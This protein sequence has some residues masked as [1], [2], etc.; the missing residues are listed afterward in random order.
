MEE[1]TDPHTAE[2]IVARHELLKAIR[3]F[4]YERGYIEVETPYLMKTAAPDPYIEPLKVFVG[5]AG[6]YYLHTSPEMGM[7]KILASGQMRIFQVC[8]AFR[9]E[10]FREHHRVEFTMAEW[11]MK[12]SYNEAIEETKDLVRHAA[13]AVGGDGAEYISRPWRIFELKDLFIRLTGIN[14]FPLDR[15]ALFDA[16]NRLGFRSLDSADTWEDLFFKLFIQEVE[17]AIQAEGPYFLKDWPAS[18]TA[19]AKKR[20][21]H[22]VERFELYMKGLEIANGYSELLDPVE[23]RE[24]LSKDNAARAR[25]AKQTFEPDEDFLAALPRIQRPVAGVSLGVDRLLMVL[26]GKERIGEVLPI[27][28]M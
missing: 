26:L 8:K 6:P 25:A 4:F 24:R 18:I 9:V 14:P 17:P 21:E 27:A 23:Q 1:R 13:G 15:E 28:C 10:E 12:G 22:T 2:V 5:D 11:Y 7:K 16:M 3:G 20:D 19:M